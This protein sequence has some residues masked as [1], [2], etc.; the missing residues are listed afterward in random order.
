MNMK[1]LVLECL[2]FLFRKLIMKLIEK[3]KKTSLEL[4]LASAGFFLRFLLRFHCL[5][6]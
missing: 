3:A 4:R 2:V 1:T 6:T 5:K